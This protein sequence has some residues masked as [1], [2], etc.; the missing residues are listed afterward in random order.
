MRINRL[1]LQAV[2][3]FPSKHVIDFD[4]LGESALFLIDGPTGAGKST[5]IDAITYAIYGRMAGSESDATRMRSTHAKPETETYVDLVFSTQSGKYRVRRAPAYDRPKSRGTGVTAEKASVLVEQLMPDGTKKNLAFQFREAATFLADRIGLSPEQFVQTVVLPQGEFAKFLRAETK[6]RQPLL[7]RIF[8]TEIYARVA[9]VLKEQASSAKKES[10][11]A[12]TD[13]KGAIVALVASAALDDEVADSLAELAEES[14]THQLLVEQLQLSM[15]DV[16]TANAAAKSVFDVEQAERHRLTEK[17][18]MRRGESAIIAGLEL[19][20]ADH[21]AAAKVFAEATAQADL[22]AVAVE[23][24]KQMPKAKDGKHDFELVL[25]RLRELQRLVEESLALEK[26]LPNKAKDLDEMTSK[27]LAMSKE[28]GDADVAVKKT[29]PVAIETAKAKVEEQTKKLPD[30]EAVSAK[31]LQLEEE[32]G[33]IA[34]LEAAQSKQEKLDSAAEKAKGKAQDAVQAAQQA[35]A[36]RYANMAA[37]LALELEDGRQCRV[38]GSLEHPNPAPMSDDAVTQEDVQNADKLAE[39]ANKAFAAADKAAAEGKAAITQ[40]AKQVKRQIEVVKADLAA[41]ESK[42]EGFEAAATQLDVSK[43]ELK[44]L[45]EELAETNSRRTGITAE[46]AALKTSQKALG[47]E[48]A[49]GRVH[50]KVM[51]QVH[52]N[53]LARKQVLA[54]QASRLRDLNAADTALKAKSVALEAAKL[55][56]AELPKEPGVGDIETAQAELAAHQSAYDEALSQK[57][58]AQ[59]KLTSF[60][61]YF[62]EILTRAENRLSVEGDSAHIVALSKWAEGANKLGQKLP[63]FV[64]QT[65]FEEVVTAANARFTTI[66]EGRYELRIPDDDPARKGSKGLGLAVFDR[67]AQSLRKTTTLSGGEQFCASLSLALGLSDVV[68]SNASGLSIDTFFI[69]EGF[70]SLDSGRL[71][72]VMQ[73]LDGLKADGRAVGLISHVE[74][75]KTAITERIDVRQDEST[76]M[77]T[78]SVNWMK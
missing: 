23:L 30:P 71:S 31:I 2:G 66:L 36:A 50:V 56:A 58:I 40:L 33:L 41:E 22:E 46:I 20:T 42:R 70:G 64:L 13:L 43:A 32:M 26:E 10:E 29:L 28:L 65:M 39:S 35:S 51:A 4:Q 38:C 9:D 77:S 34:S 5:L 17:L 59:Q 15:T 16:K 45:E 72:Q 49:E 52:E 19:A 74:E 60:N 53:L 12:T 68:L 57:S 24:G 27:L 73:M 25:E 11:A 55:R 14:S 67:P 8:A 18:E 21:M 6:E 76:N 48:L 75:L 47:D 69:D 3:P 7:E 37:E 61:T 62:N 78:L 44:S 63:A 1:E 54:E